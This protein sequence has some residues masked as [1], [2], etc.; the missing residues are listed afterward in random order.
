M[1]VCLNPKQKPTRQSNPQHPQRP[2]PPP[3]KYQTRHS[4]LVYT[5]LSPPPRTECLS[6]LQRPPVPNLPPP[7]P[8]PVRLCTAPHRT[9]PCRRVAT[10]DCLPTC[11][12]PRVR[13][14]VRSEYIGRYARLQVSAWRHRHL[15]LGGSTT[16]RSPYLGTTVPTIGG[17]GA[18]VGWD[19]VVKQDT[20]GWHRQGQKW[21]RR[22]VGCISFIE[23]DLC[24]GC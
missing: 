8:Y 9:H 18:G 15:S 6:N 17:D 5:C 3:F 4:I 12:H 14:S 21:V 7:P 23:G 20:Y 10:L 2:P 11:L 19:D 24:C 1:E 16:A 22:E 13:P